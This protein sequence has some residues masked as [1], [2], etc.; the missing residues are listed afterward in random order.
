MEERA[1][2]SSFGFRVSS[3]P[4]VRG[5]NH[6][7]ARRCLPSTRLY[8]SDTEGVGISVPEADGTDVVSFRNTNE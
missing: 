6:R 8:L 4:G 2:V 7:R 3:R 5:R 1:E